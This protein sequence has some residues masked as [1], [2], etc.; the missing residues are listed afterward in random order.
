VYVDLKF[1]GHMPQSRWIVGASFS[2]V[3]KESKKE[4]DAAQQRNATENAVNVQKAA[5]QASHGAQVPRLVITRPL[6]PSVPTVALTS[7]VPVP[8]PPKPAIHAG[9]AQTAREFGHTNPWAKE[10]SNVPAPGYSG[11]IPGR[12]AM[13]GKTNA[14]LNSRALDNFRDPAG[15][16]QRES[17]A[18]KEQGK[19]RAVN[20]TTQ[21]YQRA[22]TAHRQRADAQNTSLA[23]GLQDMR[24]PDTFMKHMARK[25]LDADQE[26]PYRGK[27]QILGYAGCIPGMVHLSGGTFTSLSRK[28]YAGE[29]ISTLNLSETT[30]LNFPQPPNPQAQAALDKYRAGGHQKL[31]VGHILGYAGF[32]PSRA[33]QVGLPFGRATLPENLEPL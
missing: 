20:T 21:L 27:C 17:Q 15:T 2:T 1:A 6:P 13:N 9:G 33:G 26:H 8:M 25:Q 18:L 28:A 12:G 4:W 32:I 10:G 5:E 16:D 14:A 11:C 30:A 7:R 31:E 22:Q 24:V 3:C 29:H 23:A 19:N